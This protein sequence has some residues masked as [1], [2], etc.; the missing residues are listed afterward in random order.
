M[1]SASVLPLD[2]RHLVS[3]ITF[4]GNHKTEVDT[5]RHELIIG[6]GDE[7]DATKLERSRQ[8]IMDLGLFK[9]VGAVAAKGPEG[10][11]IY[12]KVVEKRYWYFIPVVNHGSD[13]DVTLGLRLQIDNLFGKNKALTIRAKRKEFRNTDIQTED[14]LEIEYFYPRIFDS[15]YDFGFRID[16]DE[17]QIEEERGALSGDYFREKVTW[18]AMVSKWLN[19]E[20]PSKGVRISAGY[21]NDVFDHEFLGGDAGLF[22]DLT[23]NSLIGGVE[24]SDIVDRGTHRSGANYGVRL[25]FAD[26]VFGSETTHAQQEVFVRQYRPLNAKKLSNLNIQ[27]R[28]GNISSSVFGDATFKIANAKGIRGFER[29][30]IEGNSFFIANIEYLRSIFNKEN[31]R[32]IAFLDIGD[33]FE[34]LGDF[35]LSDPNVGVGVGLRWKIR[36]FVRTDI[37]IDL[38][39]GL[40]DNGE[41]RVY[42][43][44]RAT[45]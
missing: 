12:I 43:G 18:E 30:S 3:N 37:R 11:E 32:G 16:L 35:S 25:E 44:T 19:T 45:F 26:E 2:K 21:R 4:A 31:L 28:F 23:V 29:D 33:A 41:A 6:I 42:A 15:A 7:F 40:G 1:G 9:T 10:V 20:G 14:T 8:N 34:K 27:A 17:A 38:A 22:T 39:H 24:Y 5:L 13:G 36:S